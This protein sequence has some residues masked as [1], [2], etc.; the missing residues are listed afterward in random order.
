M[1]KCNTWYFFFLLGLWFRTGFFSFFCCLGWHSVYSFYSYFSS[2]GRGVSKKEGRNKNIQKSLRLP[3]TVFEGVVG[4]FFSCFSGYR[5]AKVEG[6]GGHGV[7]FF[8][9][10]LSLMSMIGDWFPKRIYVTWGGI[11]PGMK[12]K[13][14][15]THTRSSILIGYLLLGPIGLQYRL[16]EA[17]SNVNIDK[18][19]KV[20]N[21]VLNKCENTCTREYVVNRNTSF[22]YPKPRGENDK[23]RKM[24]K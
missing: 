12:K 22:P 5:R 16:L 20:Y 23:Q 15:N 8:P 24:T 3:G 1:G 18:G 13:D 14:Y 2:L 21:Y 7:S 6:E 17:I 9:L 19:K 11:R 4:V 10:S